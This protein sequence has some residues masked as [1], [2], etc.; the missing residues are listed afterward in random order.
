ML[1]VARFPQGM[2]RPY[3]LIGMFISMEVPNPLKL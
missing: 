1:T 2:L 3:R